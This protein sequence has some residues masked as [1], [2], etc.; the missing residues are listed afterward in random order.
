M[1][2]RSKLIGVI[3]LLNKRDEDFTDA[4]ATLL[5]ILGQVAAIALEEMQSRL[6]AEEEEAVGA[7]A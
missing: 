5:L 3:E 7:Q 2:T 1:I 4:D 6:E